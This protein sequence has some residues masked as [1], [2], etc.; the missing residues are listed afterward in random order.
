VA[1]WEEDGKLYGKIEKLIDFDPNIPDPR[2]IYCPGDLKDKPVV[3]LRVLWDLRKDGD[4]WTGGMVLDPENGKSYRCIV[5]VQ[6]NGKT[7]KVRGYI[8]ISLLGRTQYWL[9][10]Q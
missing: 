6:E 2:C 7:L 9:R 5:A 1:I 8:G 3:G 4:Q 10:D